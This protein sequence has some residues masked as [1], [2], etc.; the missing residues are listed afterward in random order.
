MGHVVTN[1]SSTVTLAITSGTPTAGGPGTL[2]GCTQSETSGVITFSGCQ[3]NTAGIGYKLHATDG[4]LT[5]ADSSAFDVK[6]PATAVSIDTTNSATAGKITA[7][8]T[9]VFTF[10]QAMNPGSILTGW[11]GN[12]TGVKVCV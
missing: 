9:I 5:A 1:D 2:S 12:S 11:S 6:V 10:S 7:G 4:T 3:I 8:D